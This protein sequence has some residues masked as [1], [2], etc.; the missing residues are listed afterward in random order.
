MSGDI[1]VS[2]IITTKNEEKNIENCLLSVTDQEFPKDRLEII[3]VDNNSSDATKKI[4]A[5]YSD[6]VFDK[7][8]ERSAQRN[9]GAEVASGRYML[10]LDADMI[11]SKT[12]VSECVVIGFPWR[13]LWMK[14]F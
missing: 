3:V 9:Y 10:Y 14:T 4:A 6:K 5:Q 11:L 8:P 12:V 13:V 7:G 2:V 1:L